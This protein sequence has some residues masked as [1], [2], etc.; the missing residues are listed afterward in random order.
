ML[1]SEKAD[2]HVTE[3]LKAG[4]RIGILSGR[5]WEAPNDVEAGKCHSRIA[6]EVS[7]DLSQQHMPGSWIVTHLGAALLS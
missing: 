2:G 5:Q 1:G 6:S 7:H 4:Y 3:A